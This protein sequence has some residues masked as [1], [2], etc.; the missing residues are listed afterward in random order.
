MRK[1]KKL[2]S[3]LCVA[4]LTCFFVVGYVISTQPAS[5]EIERKNVSSTESITNAADKTATAIEEV[6]S[7]RIHIDGAVVYPGVYELEGSDVR[8]EDGVAA[9]GGLREDAD[10]TYIN[11]AE[12][13]EDGEKVYIPVKAQTDAQQTTGSG[14]E[15]GR[16]SDT[17]N[18]LNNSTAKDLSSTSNQPSA[19][20][21]ATSSATSSTEASTKGSSLININTATLAELQTLPGVGEATAQA[22]ISDREKNGAFTSKEDLMRVSGIGEKKYAKIEA[23]ICV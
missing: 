23:S 16:A 3:L 6:C 21:S 18:A 20:A 14:L 4:L 10:T 22:I 12:S 15:N 8:I 11:L 9:A 13:V 1:N 2:I 7:I 5:I 17:S 19:T